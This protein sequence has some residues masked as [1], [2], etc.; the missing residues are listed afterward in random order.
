MTLL[1]FRPHC[2]RVEQSNL[3]LFILSTPFIISLSTLTSVLFALSAKRCLMASSMRVR[4]V[5]CCVRTTISKRLGE[6]VVAVVNQSS[7]EKSSPWKVLLLLPFP[8]PAL[9]SQRLINTLKL[10]FTET[11]PL[12]PHYSF[13]RTPSFVNLQTLIALTVTKVFR[14]ISFLHI[15]VSH[16]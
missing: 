11:V 1:T 4:M 10:N 13:H 3:S 9:I 7:R 15:C 14:T 6:C 5:I 12:S 16:A 2:Q 8:R